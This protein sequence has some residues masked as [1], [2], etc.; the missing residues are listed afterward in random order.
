MGMSEKER[1]GKERQG[2]SRRSFVKGA[3]A[4]AAAGAAAG[5]VWACAPKAPSEDEEAVEAKTERFAGV[6]RGNCAGGC[7]LDVHVRDD[8]VVRTTARDLPDPD[9]TRICTKGITHP[10]RI[11]SA[12]RLQYPMRRV[13]ERG[14]GEFERIGWDEALDEIAQKWQGYAE[15]FGPASMAV[16]YGSGNYAIC[17]GVGLAGATDRF[18]NVVGSSYIPLNVDAGHGRAFGIITGNT[19]YG[20]N[21]EPADFKNSKTLICWGANPSISQPHVMHFLMS[22]KERGAKYIVIDPAYNANAAKAD[23][24]IPLHSSTDGALAFG[25]LNEVLAQGWIQEDFLRTRTEAPFLIKDDGMLLRMSDLGVEAQKGDID[26]ST[27]EPALMDPLV[28]FDEATGGPVAAEDATKAALE[29]VSEVNGIAVKTQFALL[30]ELASAYSPERASELCGVSADDIR[31]LA[32]VYAQEGPVNTYALFGS[33]HYKNGHYNYW[34][35]Y[36]LSLVTGN[37]GSPGAAVGFS[38]LLPLIANFVGT[39]YPTDQD[40]NPAQ[41]RGVQFTIN[42]IPEVLDTGLYAGEPAPLKGVYVMCANPMATMAQRERTKYW[43][44]NIEF[45]VVADMNMTETATYA[46]ILLP[47]AHWFETTDLFTSYSSAPY[48][49]WQDKVIEPQFE[50]KSDFDIMKLLADKMGYGEFFDMS[51]EDYIALWLDSDAARAM[52]I[53]FEQVKADKVARI[54]PGETFVSFEDG[55]YATPSGRARFY[56]ETVT[57]DY[58]IGQQIDETKEKVPY[59]EPATEA[60]VNSPI[61]ATYPYQVLSEHM[62]TRTHT[63]WW[64]VRYM[65]DYEPDPMVRLNPDDAATLGITEGDEV[66]LSNARGYVVMKA[67][68]NSGLPRGMVSSPRSF[69]ADEFIDGHF[70][71]ISSNE[72]NQVCA[73]QAFND[74]AVTIERL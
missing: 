65:D 36:A 7:F 58:D 40:G 50:A 46:D 33:N 44:T 26:P 31:E 60:D 1:A 18:I 70:A 19:L 9:Y 5:S 3:A 66:K 13:G 10:A 17:S 51:E 6:C 67:T 27:G 32:R 28:V 39:L 52:G 2:F 74:V 21:N 25:A 63:Q 16:M 11:Y 62:R 61:R 24:H 54:L 53:S 71:D 22:A 57:P 15:E 38:E 55:V 23:W 48:I 35:L 20:T 8:K 41:G 69:Q 29:G 4:V 43:L 56:Q 49:L 64:D 59:W 72:F 47:A 68:I 37:S 45:V 42:K 73:N 12:E 34:S 14:A 30:R